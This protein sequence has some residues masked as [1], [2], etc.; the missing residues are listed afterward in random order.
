MGIPLVWTKSQLECEGA[1]A[2]SESIISNE[3]V[4]VVV[5]IVVVVVR[6]VEVSA[7]V[8]VKVNCEVG[9]FILK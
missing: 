9:Y 3:V 7:A 6:V 8:V 4:I 1:L 2:C 5:V